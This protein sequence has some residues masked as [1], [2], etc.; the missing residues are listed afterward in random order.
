MQM[1][2]SCVNYNQV[3]MSELSIVFEEKLKFF[4]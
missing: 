1:F 4:N 3:K 2:V